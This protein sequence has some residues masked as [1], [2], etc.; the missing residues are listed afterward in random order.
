MR[1]LGS[2]IEVIIKISVTRATTATPVLAVHCQ[3]FPTIFVMAQ[4]A[5][6]GAL[7]ISCSPMVISICTWVTSLVERVIRLGV[8]KPLISSMEKLST[9]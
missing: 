2:V 6:T 8:E 3:L 9:L 4:T 7:M 5:I 1:N